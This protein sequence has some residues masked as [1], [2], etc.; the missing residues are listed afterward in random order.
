MEVP[1]ITRGE[2]VIFEDELVVVIFEL[3]RP[4]CC[5]QGR[6]KGGIMDRAFELMV[7]L[8]ILAISTGILLYI[9]HAD[10]RQR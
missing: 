5:G 8:L 3:G 10:R 2:H 1:A 6:P 7:G 4:S 9:R